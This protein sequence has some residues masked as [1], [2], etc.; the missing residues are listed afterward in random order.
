MPEVEAVVVVQPSS[1]AAAVAT[2]PATPAVVVIPGVV[3]SGGGGG[4]GTSVTTSRITSAA[5]SGYRVMSE[6]PDG[7]VHYADNTDLSDAYSI[8]GLSL[9]AASLGASI[10]IRMYGYVTNAG[11]AWTPG[12][13][14][15]LS[16][17]GHLTQTPPQA[18]AVFSMVVG[19]ALSPT[20][21]LVRPELPIEL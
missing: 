9:T 2:V 19:L 10:N 3:S 1:P 5:L 7:T 17:I 16:D 8:I 6:D 14:I 20:T 4:D 21:M 18:P 15:F 13:P 12:Q 11:W